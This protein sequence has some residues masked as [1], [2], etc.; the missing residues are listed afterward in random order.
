MI[1]RELDGAIVYQVHYRLKNGKKMRCA[2]SG[3]NQVDYEK[4]VADLEQ[5]KDIRII[6]KDIS[7]TYVTLFD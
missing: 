2:Y 3:D 4:I 5:R 6:L 7:Y 1:D